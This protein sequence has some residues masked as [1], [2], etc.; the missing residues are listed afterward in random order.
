M[1]TFMDFYDVAMN[2][3]ANGLSAADLQAIRRLLPLQN[4]WFLR[5]AIN[6]AQGEIAEGLD[7][8]GATSGTFA[9]RAL[10]TRPLPSSTA[11]GGTGTGQ[12]VQ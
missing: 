3:T 10:E 8:N 11:R 5:R 12:V 7:L 6:A 1:G 2:R 4:L 9:G